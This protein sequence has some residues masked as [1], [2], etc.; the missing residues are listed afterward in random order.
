M[1]VL[2][3]YRYSLTIYSLVLNLQ[4]SL[5][6]K[7]GVFL[8]YD[9]RAMSYKLISSS[10]NEKEFMKTVNINFVISIMLD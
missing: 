2:I 4:I 9:G 6:G 5:P 10:G 7:N 1:H 3:L 8:H